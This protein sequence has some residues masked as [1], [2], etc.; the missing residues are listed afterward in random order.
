MFFVA[1]TR[2]SVE[3]LN[4]RAKEAEEAWEFI[5]WCDVPNDSTL[6]TLAS[7]DDITVRQP[8]EISQYFTYEGWAALWLAELFREAQQ[9][10]CNIT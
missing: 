5:Q 9:K 1:T 8:K 3:E 7:E 2:L 6:H 4:D 10:T